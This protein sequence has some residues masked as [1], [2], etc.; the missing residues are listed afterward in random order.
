MPRRT[1]QGVVTSDKQDKTVTVEVTRRLAHP[2][3]KK[4]VSRRKRYAAHDEKNQF[5]VG[6]IVR[7]QECAPI[8]KRKSWTVVSNQS[9]QG[10]N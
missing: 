4:I 1:L 10:A 9:E 2:V 8:S 7:I 6:D 3:Y 5:A